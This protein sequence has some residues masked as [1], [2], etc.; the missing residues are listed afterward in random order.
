MSDQYPSSVNW[1]LDNILITTIDIE[2]Q[3]ENGFPNPQDA[4]EPML[5]ITVKNHQNKQIVVFG[6]GKYES[7]RTDVT[8]IEC[9]SEPHLFKEFLLFWEKIH[10][11]LSLVGTQSSLMF[12]ISVIVSRIYLAR[13]NSKDYRLGEWLQKG[14]SIIVVENTNCMKSKVFAHLDYL[15]LY[16]KFTYTSQESYS[17]NHIAYV[18]LGEKKD[19]NPYDTFRDWYTK[20]FN[21]LLTTIFL[22]WN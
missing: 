11:T 9:S 7:K 21:L 2:V 13:M 18:E 6:I 12:H 17:L 4:L 14:K 1:D 10:Q 15:D 20:D 22:M 5:S 16:H 19:E 8:Y 3:C